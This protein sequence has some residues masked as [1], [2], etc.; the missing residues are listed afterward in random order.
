MSEREEPTLYLIKKVWR[1][2]KGNR[3]KVV[4]FVILFL[5]ANIILLLQPLVIAKLL[6]VIQLQGITKENVWTL[7]GIASLFFLL[8]LGFWIFHGPA[9]VIERK[10]AFHVRANYKNYLIKGVFRLSPE[11]HAQHH[12]G[13]TIDK[14]EKGTNALFQFSQN[15][16]E[17]IEVLVRFLGSIIVLFYFDVPAGFITLFGVMVAIGVIIQFDKKLRTYYR[18]INKSENV[19]SQRIYDTISN[20]TT[21]IILRVE[22]LST[23]AIFK[24]I[25]H[26]YKIF[27]RNIKLNELKWGV[28]GLLSAF[29]IFAVV[30]VYIYHSLTTG[31]VILV[32]TVYA[33]YGYVERVTG[34]F[35]RF[36]GRYSEFVV[37]RTAVENA[38][39]LSKEFKKKKIV[40]QI[41]IGKTWKQ[42]KIQGLTFSYHGKDNE[43]LH[44]NNI[45]ITIKRKEK[46]A[47][48]GESGSGKTTFLKLLRGLYPARKIKL[49]VDEQEIPQLENISSKISLLP[50]EPELFATTIRENITMGTAYTTQT[51]MKHCDLAN[52]TPVLKRL[53]KGLESS[54]GEKGVNLSGGEKQRLALARGLLACQQKQFV[55]L[56]EPTSSVDARNERL[57]YE[58]IFN[59]FKNKTV[60]STIHRLHLLHMFD[61]I[62]FFDKGKIIASGNLDHLLRTSPEF[63]SLWKKYHQTKEETQ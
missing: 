34:L 43:D 3:H 19:L 61:T 55:L 11:W 26:P 5:I 46:V 63:R 35:S 48:I 8:P 16:F 40:K 41:P 32:G 25:M 20:I 31:A 22:K 17:I 62:Y 60:I 29:I 49:Y 36:A 50:Q 38:E 45:S 12:S 24:R 54:I 2:S 14:I 9:R 6:D 23:K 30:G 1:F 59:E 39:E 37:N 15:S 44:L 53:P 27:I 33:L 21:I 52:F 13:D 28:S 18:E 10:N 56:D 4:L 42:L 57:I 51:I 58:N 47:L 7:V